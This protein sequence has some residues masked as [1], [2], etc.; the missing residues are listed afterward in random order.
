V[1]AG[2]NSADRQRAVF[3]ASESPYRLL[4]AW[5]LVRVRVRLHEKRGKRHEMPAHHKLEQF[6]DEYLAAL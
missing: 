4:T 6:L 1:V 3:E 5:S 2:S